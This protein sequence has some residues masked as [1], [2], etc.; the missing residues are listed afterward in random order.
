MRLRRK[1]ELA[2]FS[3]A[4]ASLAA[5][6]DPDGLGQL[7]DMG[8]CLRDLGGC[9][10][11]PLRIAN[12][13]VCHILSHRVSGEID[14]EVAE[15]PVQAFRVLVW[16]TPL[17]PPPLARP[18]KRP[19]G[20]RAG[21]SGRFRDDPGCFACMGASGGCVACMARALV[22]PGGGFPCELWPIPADELRV[23]SWLKP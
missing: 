3:L 4:L 22:R 12:E 19:C 21:A 2:H 13:K 10:G 17:V 15:R 1:A 7:G 5:V 18:G 14:G 8:T 16:R 11:G 23:F 20:A 6:L 9:L